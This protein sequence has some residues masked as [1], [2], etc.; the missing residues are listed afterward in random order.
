MAP[1]PVVE[2]A[3][4][5]S[6]GPEGGPRGEGFGGTQRGSADMMVAVRSE[7]N[8]AVCREGKEG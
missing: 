6:Y 7:A 1:I 8:W 3:D 2:S 5:S 4:G